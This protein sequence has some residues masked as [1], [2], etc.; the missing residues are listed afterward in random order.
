V[1]R[2]CQHLRL[3]A[4]ALVL[5]LAQSCLEFA[6]QSTTF[7]YDPPSDTLRMAQV[8]HGIFGGEKQ[9]RLSVKE[10]QQLRLVLDEEKTF[11]YAN[12]IFEYSEAAAHQAIQ[13]M[14]KEEAGKDAHERA[15]HAAGIAMYESLIENVRVRTGGFYRDAEGRL[16]GWQTVS[17]R[18]TAA[19]L[20]RAN[21][22]FS[23][24]VLNSLKDGN[25]EWTEA[26]VAL[27]KAAANE[28]YQ[29]LSVGANWLQ[30]RMPMTAEDYRRI[31]RDLASPEPEAQVPKTH[32]VPRM[33][34]R[35]AGI[36]IEVDMEARSYGE[37]QHWLRRL[38]GMVAS[39]LDLSWADNTMTL[40]IG[41]EDARPG[42]ISMPVFAG[43][44]DNATQDVER[45]HDIPAKFDIDAQA[46]EFL[47]RK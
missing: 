4:L 10:R 38:E 33:R 44:V 40:R 21:P 15:M 16:C 31:R 5:V 14:R 12:W 47:H 29:W 32:H 23:K 43:Y 25:D 41:L 13:R 46:R 9:Q 34:G 19:V 39:D 11:F 17:I 22:A 26:S 7:V 8:Y 36:P 1:A 24:L 2:L 35:I 28:D 6:E 42:R 37:T 30:L 3:G 18:H 45:L 20:Q 27:L